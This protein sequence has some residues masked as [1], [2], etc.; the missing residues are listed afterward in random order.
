[1]PRKKARGV[2][3]ER[4][5]RELDMFG[6]QIGFNIDGE[7]VHKTC[8]GAT[9]SLIIFGWCAI[10]LNYLIQQQLFNTLNHPLTTIL[11]RNYYSNNEPIR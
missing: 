1:M 6:H 4:A 7:D 10:I 2:A 8:P 5:Y 11:H 3:I 9:A